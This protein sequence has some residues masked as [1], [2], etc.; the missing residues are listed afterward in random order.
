MRDI[1]LRSNLE[2]VFLSASFFM[3]WLQASFSQRLFALIGTLPAH[4]C[5]T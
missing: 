1:K 2:A 5:Q 3:S 4:P